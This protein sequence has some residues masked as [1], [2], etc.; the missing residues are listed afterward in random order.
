M[1]RKE[2]HWIKDS[3][4]DG[5]SCMGPR[6]GGNGKDTAARAGIRLLLGGKGAINGVGQGRGVRV[7]LGERK[8]RGK[9]SK[10]TRQGMR[11]TMERGDMDVTWA[12][13]QWTDRDRRRQ[14]R[15]KNEGKKK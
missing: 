5:W 9:K 6:E 2:Q 11:V 1:K 3:R 10:R 7:I 14:G 8:K 4:S 13:W 12:T 15:E